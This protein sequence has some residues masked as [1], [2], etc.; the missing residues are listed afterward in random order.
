LHW[1]YTREFQGGFTNRRQPFGM[2]ANTGDPAKLYVTNKLE[3][4]DLEFGDAVIFTANCPHAGWGY[5]RPDNGDVFASY[6][7]LH[8]Y[9]EAAVGEEGKRGHSDEQRFLEKVDEYLINVGVDILL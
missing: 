9:C 8:A 5:P 7:R 1:D 6:Y 3:L 2:V 4:L